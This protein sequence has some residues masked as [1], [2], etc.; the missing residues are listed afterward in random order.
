[1]ETIDRR[2]NLSE[3]LGTPEEL[4]YI[5]RA[6]KSN[7]WHF[8]KR[9]AAFCPH[10]YTLRNQWRDRKAY[11]DLVHFIWKYGLEAQYGNT[12]AKI[13]WFDHETGYYYFIYHEDHDEQGTAT[14]KAYLINRAKIED[15]DFWI[16]TVETV[17]CKA[18]P[19]HPV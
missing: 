19:K 11:N 9:Y 8:A 7:I 12:E 14:E 6:V 10:E 15:Y 16:D 18:R 3:T 1:M 4:E 5:R 17:R 13:Y 2:R